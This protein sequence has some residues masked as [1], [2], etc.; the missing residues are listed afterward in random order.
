MLYIFRLFAHNENIKYRWILGVR[1]ALSPT[2]YYHD[3]Q[4]QHHCRP[5]LWYLSIWH[6]GQMSTNQTENKEQK[7]STNTEMNKNQVNSKHSN[8]N[9]S[10][11]ISKLIQPIPK[12]LKTT[13]SYHTLIPLL[14]VQRYDDGIN[15]SVIAVDIWCYILVNWIHFHLNG[16]GCYRPKSKKCWCISYLRKKKQ[17]YA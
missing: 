11:Y 3:Q 2:S 13:K 14:N 15:M 5:F 6:R 9:S 7:R 17:F 4:Q 1:Y 8:V 16:F 12:I 10:N